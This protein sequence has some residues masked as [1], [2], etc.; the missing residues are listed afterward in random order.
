MDR[1]LPHFSFFKK[2]FSGAPLYI[3]RGSS[4]FFF[5]YPIPPATDNI[6]ADSADKCQ[7]N[8]IFASP[9]FQRYPTGVFFGT[10]ISFFKKFFSGVYVDAPRFILKR[11]NLYVRMKTTKFCGIQLFPKWKR[12]LIIWPIRVWLSGTA[13]RTPGPFPHLCCH[14]RGVRRLRLWIRCRRRYP[15]RLLLRVGGKRGLS[16]S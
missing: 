12:P 9:P 3:P 14:I 11:V 15:A 16:V 4:S 5:I 13:D 1:P 2:F 7:Y 6:L 10:L 8:T